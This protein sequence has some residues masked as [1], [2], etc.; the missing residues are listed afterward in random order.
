MLKASR[1]ISDNYGVGVCIRLHHSRPRSLLSPPRGLFSLLTSVGLH[2]LPGRATDIK[3]TSNSNP[4]TNR[5]VSVASKP[6]N[7][8]R[9]G[10]REWVPSLK[11]NLTGKSYAFSRAIVKLHVLRVHVWLIKHQLLSTR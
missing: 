6:F 7:F 4:V 9:Q 3:W 2:I 10:I 11:T 1:L 5:R 8:E